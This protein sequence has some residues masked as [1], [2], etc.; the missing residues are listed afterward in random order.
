MKLIDQIYFP[1]HVYII[2]VTFLQLYFRHIVVDAKSAFRMHNPFVLEKKN[3]NYNFKNCSDKVRNV[4]LT[5]SSYRH[6]C[7]RSRS[8]HSIILIVFR[9]VEMPTHKSS[10]E[11]I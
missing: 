4:L 5:L 1:F 3:K 6:N 11:T 2:W 8:E 10:A 9:F 7:D